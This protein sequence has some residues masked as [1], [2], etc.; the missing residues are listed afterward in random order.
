[1]QGTPFQLNTPHYTPPQDP[2]SDKNITA[3][4]KAKH[5]MGMPGL[6]GQPM[7]LPIAQPTHQP[8][9]W[10]QGT[11]EGTLTPDVVLSTVQH[12][13]SVDELVASAAH[14]QLCLSV[15]QNDLPPA[16]D[17]ERTQLRGRARV[18]HHPG[19]VWTSTLEACSIA[20]QIRSA[21]YLAS[22]AK[23]VKSSLCFV[24]K[25]MFLVR[26]C[27]MDGGCK[28]VE[29]AKRASWGGS[30]DPSSDLLFCP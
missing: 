16:G 11:R 18:G 4:H 28:G 20:P 8:Q 10:A 22:H 25:I 9:R 19:R 27:R 6:K 5:P 29:I 7:E 12:V 30:A 26:I 2:C 1:M 24:L 13:S 17:R 3:R 14:S 15:A 21:A 23:G